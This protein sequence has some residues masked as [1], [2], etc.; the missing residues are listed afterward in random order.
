MM[1]ELDAIGGMYK[2][3]ATGVD[4]FKQERVEGCF[5]NKTSIMFAMKGFLVFHEMLIGV[6][7]MHLR[8]ISK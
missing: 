3:T 2:T 5:D 7:Q 6:N 1:I 4:Y 8:K